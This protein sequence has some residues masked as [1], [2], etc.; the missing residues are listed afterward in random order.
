MTDGSAPPRSPRYPITLRLEYTRK[1]LPAA[2]AGTGHSCSLSDGGACLELAESLTLATRL[3]LTL[4]T[5]CGDLTLEAE[6][7]WVGKPGALGQGILHGVRFVQVPP[8]QKHALRKLI[9]RLGK[10]AQAGTRVPMRLPARCTPLR[11]AGAA[12]H[13][14][15]DDLSRE[16]LALRLPQRLAVG[17]AVEVTL[18]TPRGPCTAEATVVWVEAADRPSAGDFTHHGLQ[19]TT[20][21]ALPDLL[22]GPGLARNEGRYEE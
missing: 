16:G 13:G 6:V 9:H 5:D 14:W 12:L 18:A 8:D 20:P 4:H 21:N 17:T 22:R 7:I 2:P 19:F 15:T 1:G 10:V 3:T 11:A